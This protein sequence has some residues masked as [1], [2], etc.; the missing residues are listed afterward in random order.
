MSLVEC[1]NEWIY[2]TNNIQLI[3]CEYYESRDCLLL[4]IF[5][6]YGTLN[7]IIATNRNIDRF[8]QQW[9]SLMTTEVEST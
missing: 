1:F 9:M 6:F 4:S 3:F 7:T 5:D 2:F 8:S